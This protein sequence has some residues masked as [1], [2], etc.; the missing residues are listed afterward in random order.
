MENREDFVVLDSV[1]AKLNFLQGRTSTP[2]SGTRRLSA[3]SK[4]AVLKNKNLIPP[5]HSPSDRRISLPRATKLAPKHL[6][7]ESNMPATDKR[8]TKQADPTPGD[9]QGPAVTGAGPSA[10][11][12]FIQEQLAAL[13]A[14]ISSVKTDIEKAETRTVEKMDSKVDDLAGKLQ[15]RMTRAETDLATLGAEVANTRQQLET[16]RLAAV[17]QQLET[18]RLA[19]VE[20]ARTLPGLVEE[21]VSARLAGAQQATK[22]LGAL[23]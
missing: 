6:D 19:A 10:T 20:N 5:L 15:T 22:Q 9:D 1:Q 7:Q 14:M 17:E 8:K 11:D 23:E 16:M 4:A 2:N 13:T 3:A 21:A 12:K 18:M